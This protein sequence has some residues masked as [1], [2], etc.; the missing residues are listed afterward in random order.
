MPSRSLLA[1]VRSLLV[2]F[3]LAVLP[4]AAAAATYNSWELQSLQ[5]VAE[6]KGYVSVSITLGPSPFLQPTPEQLAQTQIKRNALLAE[7]GDEILTEGFDTSAQYG[8]INSYVSLKGLTILAASSNVLSFGFDNRSATVYDGGRFAAIDA[9]IDRIGVATVAVDLNLPSFAF[10][11]AADGS[12][13]YRPSPAQD[14][15]FAILLPSFLATLPQRGIV[16]RD[17]LDATNVPAPTVYLTVHRDG[18]YA[19]Q[20]SKL[21][22]SLRLAGGSTRQAVSLDRDALGIAAEQGEVEVMLRL[23]AGD[24]YSDLIFGAAMQTQSAASQRAFDAIL[25]PLGSALVHRSVLV[26]S[27][28]N[29]LRL[30]R[31]A[32]TQLFAN[33]DPRLQSISVVKPAATDPFGLRVSYN[34]KLAQATLGYSFDL[35]SYVVGKRGDLFVAFHQA[36]NQGAWWLLGTTGWRPVDAAA[37]VACFSGTLAASMQVDILPTATDL[38]SLV[39]GQFYAGYGVRSNE[40]ASV[41]DAWQDMSRNMTVMTIWTIM[42]EPAPAPF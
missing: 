28:I 30:N 5:R 40:A 21:V 17:Q 23:Q 19:L 20:Q 26:P 13:V 41:A 15:E 27:G 36:G 14:A 22:R 42:A 10:E 3:S 37:P 2:C 31:E 9:E 1:V 35:P 32:I 6:Q 25:A 39:G 12:T 8:Y 34:G 7:L 24:F 4:L 18:F 11:W 29:F 16:N 33:P 38:R